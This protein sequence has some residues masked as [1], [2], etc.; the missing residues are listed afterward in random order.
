MKIALVD[1]L[2]AAPL[3]WGLKA[4]HRPDGWELCFRTPAQCADMLR[5]GEAK[6]GIVPS[7]EFDRIPDL[8]M[9]VPLGV[10]CAGEVRSVLLFCGGPLAEIGTVMLDP[11]SRTSQSLVKIL[12]RTRTASPPRYAEKAWDGG[13]LA[14]DAA[15]L[16]IGDRAL[17]LRKG[18]GGTVVDLGREWFEETGR[19]FV[20]AVWAAQKLPDEEFV[21]E[22]LLR[23]YHF[24]AEHLEEIV[25]KYAPKVGLSQEEV[26]DYLTVALHHP[27]REP[28]YEGLREFW[29]RAWLER[30]PEIES[31]GETEIR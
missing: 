31:A 16:V 5:S 8:C 17:R 25:T 30:E 1:Y 2:N 13:S 26:R 27:L 7:L 11:T 12:L 10:A 6:V 29:E 9:P 19:P 15:A 21:A 22:A 18:W 4:G 20:F 3:W 24:G 28:D 23:S 14:P